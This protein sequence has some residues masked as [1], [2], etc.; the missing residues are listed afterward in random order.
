MMNNQSDSLIVADYVV[1]GTGSAGA[2]LVTG[3]TYDGLFY[4]PTVL[5]NVGP[6]TPAYTNEIFGPVAVVRSF[7]DRR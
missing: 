1:V 7:A 3:G 2:K 6:E 5:T 4:R